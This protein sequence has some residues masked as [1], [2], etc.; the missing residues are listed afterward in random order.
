MELS[1]RL[2]L[3]GLLLVFSSCLY[4]QDSVRLEEN[5]TGYTPE[6]GELVYGSSRFDI[7][8]F[9]TNGKYS[10]ITDL[11]AEKLILLDSQNLVKRIQKFRVRRSEFFG[12]GQMV[13]GVLL[14]L[15]QSE[16]NSFFFDVF[17]MD[18]HSSYS[19]KVEVSNDYK[20]K[21]EKSR[22]GK[23]LMS[24]QTF[25]LSESRELIVEER[26]GNR[27]VVLEHDLEFKRYDTLYDQGGDKPMTV[28]NPYSNI[29]AVLSG[30]S[31]FILDAAASRLFE[32]TE[33]TLSLV[34]IMNADDL[35][36]VFKGTGRPLYRNVRLLS[37]VAT[38][39]IYFLAQ[40]NEGEAKY[41]VYELGDSKEISEVKALSFDRKYN[42]K[43]VQIFDGMAYVTYSPDFFN[44]SG[45]YLYKVPL[46]SK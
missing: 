13:N 29:S 33:S 15:D 16:M 19:Y 24:R 21:T 12:R 42:A 28:L 45:R 22:L 7:D 10:L 43:I 41:K 36:S 11:D 32:Y 35:N 46:I 4:G 44:Y 8:L 3:V 5:L 18:A 14:H 40:K 25:D 2:F 37:D 1:N 38:R 30:G 26:P 17:D 34:S 20:V 6:I 23:R 39:K 27:R 9:I 31:Y